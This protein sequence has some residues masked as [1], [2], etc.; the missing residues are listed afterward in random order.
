MISVVCWIWRGEREYLPEHVN[1]LRNM[2][3]QHLHLPHRFICISDTL[4]GF[5]DG[6]EVVPEPEAARKLGEMRSPEGRMMPSCYRRLWLFSREARDV[7]GDRI[8]LTDVDAII[9]GDVTHLVEREE[10]FVGWRPIITWGN[11]D[12][13]AGGM[14]LM[15]TGAFSDVYEDFDANGIKAARDAGYRGSDQAWISYK[16]RGRAAH[17]PDNAGIFSFG[18]FNKPTKPRSDAR[19]IHFAGHLKPWHI[20]VPQWVREYYKGAQVM[21]QPSDFRSLVLRHRGERIV[22]MGGAPSLDEHL[23]GLQADVWISVNEHGARRRQVDYV[24]A[25]DDRHNGMNRPMRDVIREYTDAPIIGPWP[26]PTA[27]HQLVEWPGAPRKGLSG[28][29]AVWAA[30]AMGGHP[31]ILAGFDAYGGTKV[32]EAQ[33][34][35]PS[36]YA[37]VRVVGGGP[38]ASVWQEYKPREKF[39]NYKAHTAIAGVIGSDNLITVRAR[40]TCLLRGGEL[41]AGETMQVMR[42]EVARLL[43]HRMLEEV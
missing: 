20:G 43:R 8:L 39:A 7:L 18:D 40:K 41:P 6:I 31:V 12:R 1:A 23:N 10:P 2:F 33:K 26:W 34:I 9:T 16:L 21:F 4:E 36:V 30:W 17:W 32:N 24:L 11:K 19:V 3:A 29:V 42:Y 37:E 5:D 25:M 28:M 27:D 13:V 35:A 14:Y 22:V 15:T 38:L